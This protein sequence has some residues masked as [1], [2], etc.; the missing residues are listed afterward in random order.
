MLL[1]DTWNWDDYIAVKEEELR[2]ELQGELEARYQE[3]IRQV[4]ERNQRLEEENRRLR[5]E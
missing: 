3:Q 1:S 5:G 4:L 2:A